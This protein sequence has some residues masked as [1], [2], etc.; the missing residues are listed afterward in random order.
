MVNP[1]PTL[2]RSREASEP[3]SRGQWGGPLKATPHPP[4]GDVSYGGALERPVGSDAHGFR[5]R[6]PRSALTVR[7]YCRIRVNTIGSEVKA[8]APAGRGMRCRSQNDRRNA[9]LGTDAMVARVFTVRI[10]SL[11]TF[12]I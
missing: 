9:W 3:Y 6:R 12:M 4:G 11:G 8:Y 5:S 1:N 10:K 2:F 7:N